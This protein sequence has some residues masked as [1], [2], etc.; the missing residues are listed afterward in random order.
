MNAMRTARSAY[1]G[2]RAGT[3]TARDVEYQVFSRITRD[4]R[5]AIDDPSAGFP[6]LVAALHENRKLWNTLAADVADTQ[7]GL[8]DMLRA[9]ILFLA[10]FTHHETDNIL[11]GGGN[12]R[13]LVDIN[14]AVMRGL[15]N[16][17]EVNP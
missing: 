5:R 6:S 9:R 17:R 13:A 7:N 1:S 14:M 15:G 3:R 2:V 10:E 11:S 16:Q 12:A 8:P 4:M